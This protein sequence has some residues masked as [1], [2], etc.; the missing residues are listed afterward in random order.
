MWHSTS[1]LD[2]RNQTCIP[3]KQEVKGTLETQKL[4]WA[5]WSKD[6]I[7]S[8][9]ISSNQPNL[10]TR[11]GQ[12][13]SMTI[14]YY[15]ISNADKS[16][17]GYTVNWDILHYS[18]TIQRDNIEPRKGGP[19]HLAFLLQNHLA[20]ESSRIHSL[21]KSGSTIAIFP[22]KEKLYGAVPCCY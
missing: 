16:N 12:F 3:L 18:S 14:G 2:G 1:V 5:R 6:T 7:K 4:F 17:I 13:M 10:L 20:E 8:I 19:R 21:A 11:L 22:L 9:P 15:I